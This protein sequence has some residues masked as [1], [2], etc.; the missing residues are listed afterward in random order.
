MTKP[1]VYMDIK[2]TVPS[3]A[4]ALLRTTN[5]CVNTLIVMPR[6]VIMQVVVKS[7]EASVWKQ[8]VRSHANLMTGPR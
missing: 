2:V 4:H 5:C 1:S 3:F 7:L 8:D 6:Y